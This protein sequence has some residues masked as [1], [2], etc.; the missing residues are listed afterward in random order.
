MRTKVQ[1]GTEV[2]INVHVAPME[3]KTI[4]D[5]DFSVEVYC[6]GI[7][8]QKFTKSE[9]NIVDKENFII[10]LDTSKLGTGVLR[11]KMV[12]Q[13]PDLDF[14]DGKRTEIVEVDS[15]IQIV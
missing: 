14:A 7:G 8:S 15:G 9:V 10:C 1:R 6:F 12:A 11:V 2:K 4:R 3:G 5:Y 13:I